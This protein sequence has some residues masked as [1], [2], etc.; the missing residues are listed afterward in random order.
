M[1]RDNA[2]V[3]DD[4]LSDVEGVILPEAGDYNKHVYHL[5]AIRTENRDILIKALAEKEIYCGIHY[6]VPIHLQEAYKFLGLG[7]GSFPVSEKCANEFLSLPM[8]PELTKEQAE[9]VTGEI[10]GFSLEEV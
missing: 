2:K 4:L 7:I 10:R 9:Y 6:P 8:F 3:Y 1:R 5:Y